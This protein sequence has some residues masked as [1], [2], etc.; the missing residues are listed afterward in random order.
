M[1]T[2]RRRRAHRRRAIQSARDARERT[3][4]KLLD[5]RNPVSRSVLAKA[6]GPC[7]RNAN[8]YPERK[9]VLARIMSERPMSFALID[10]LLR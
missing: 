8:P 1:T 2:K 6:R 5:P 4:R 9:Q 7:L 10:E 3:G